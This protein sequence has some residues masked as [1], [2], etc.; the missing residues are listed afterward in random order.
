[1]PFYIVKLIKLAFGEQPSNAHAIDFKAL[2]Q[3]HLA[4]LR[5]TV[6]HLPLD[7]YRCT[8]NRA[9]TPM[10]A[11]VVHT[12]AAHTLSAILRPGTAPISDWW[13]KLLSLL[14]HEVS[15]QNLMKCTI[16]LVESL[17]LC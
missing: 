6:G 14:Q 10:L 9:G 7:T 5:L 12:R 1:M 3:T 4:F 17:Q 13:K 15:F 11:P 8:F 16:I 2:Y